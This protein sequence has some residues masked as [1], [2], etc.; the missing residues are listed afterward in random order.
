MSIASND[1]SMQLEC[2]LDCVEQAVV[3]LLDLL[4]LRKAEFADTGID[5]VLR[6]AL[7]ELGIAV[8]EIGGIDAMTAAAREASIDAPPND[9]WRIKILN[10]A[11]RGVGD[12]RGRWLR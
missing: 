11:W 6:A 12:R 7:H 8:F 4:V 1:R 9:R 2:Q 3:G 10:R 5:S